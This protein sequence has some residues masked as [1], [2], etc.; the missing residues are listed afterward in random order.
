MSD[1]EQTGGASELDVLKQRA[2]LMGINFSN[3][4]S[5]ETLRE[6]VNAKIAAD[7]Q[8]DDDDAED[9]VDNDD[10]ADEDAE[11]SQPNGLDAAAQVA[12]QKDTRPPQDYKPQ[13]DHDK[14]G[15]NGGSLPK[16]ERKLTKTQIAAQKRAKLFKEQ[17]KLVRCR[18]Q[19]LDPKK[20]NLPG[21]IFTVANRILGTVRKFVPYG[22][23]TE[24]GYHLPYIIYRELESRRFLNIRTIKD[25]RTGHIRVDSSWAKEFAIEVLPPLTEEELAKLA[26][27]QKAA[28]SVTN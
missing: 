12:D 19:N 22:E 28:G 18:I 6:R 3:N 11:A 23:V 10:Q 24:D 25:R 2:R 1:N 21:E 7:G 20:A 5:L 14:D 26:N 15:H 27:A 16:A 8:I 13:L 4:I 9:Q 17:M